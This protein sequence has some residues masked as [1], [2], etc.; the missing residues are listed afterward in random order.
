MNSTGGF[1]CSR[2]G[3]VTLAAI[4]KDGKWYCHNCV[5]P[6]EV[7]TQGWMCPRCGVVNSP[8]VMQCQCGPR[9]NITVSGN[10]EP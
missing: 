8:F 2:C 9:Y 10:S 5:P 7:A 3:V 4:F 1:G 6:Q